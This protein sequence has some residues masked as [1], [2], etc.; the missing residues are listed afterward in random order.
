MFHNTKNIFLFIL[1][2]FVAHSCDDTEETSQ[3]GHTDADGMEIVEMIDGEEGLLYSE[4]NGVID[5][6]FQSGI[7]SGNE[8]DLTVHF[9]DDECEE[10]EH[11]DDDHDGHDHGDDDHD[12]HGD[13]EAYLEITGY[14]TSIISIT[15]GGHDDHGDE[16]HCE[17]FTT[18]AECG[19]H[20]ECEWHADDMACEDADHDDHGDH[21]EEHGYTF[22]LETLAPGET[23]FEVKLMHQG[24]SDYTS[25]TITIVVE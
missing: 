11:D 14:D 7:P 3:D 6:N 15:V 16:E 2:A 24:H 8:W 21:D 10:L 23:T 22:E 25:S 9:L 18:E 1:V 5:N 19:E 20:D 17:D 12:D 4:C 13:D